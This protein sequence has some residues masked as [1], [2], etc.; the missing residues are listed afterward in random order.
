M[1]RGRCLPA[2]LGL[3]LLSCSSK[4]DSKQQGSGG[5]DLSGQY[6]L[7]FKARG[8]KMWF[9]FALTKGATTATMQQP[10]T[11]ELD[12]KKPKL[13]IDPDPA[14]C[15]LTAT[16]H[17]TIG[18]VLASLTLDP[19]TNKV[20]GLV[21]MSGDRDGL[22][23]KGVRD[24]GPLTSPHECVKP[25]RYELVVP[26]EQEWESDTPKASCDAASLRLP[27]LVEYVGDELAVD[28]LDDKGDAAWGAED[29]YEVEPCKV[30]VRFRRFESYAYARLTFAGDSVT[31]DASSVNVEMGEVGARWRCRA[32][33]PMAWVEKK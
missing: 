4:S 8:Q 21:R 20:T 19:K 13:D 24:T 29:I 22:A 26:A 2:L 17:A 11:M 25:G 33:Q 30:E 5:C 9:R 3:A 15:K 27:F 16:A 10:M 14:S 28:Q 6:R 32:K 23:L 18:D 12:P 7:R 31:A 1:T